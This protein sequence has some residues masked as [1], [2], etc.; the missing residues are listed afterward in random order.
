MNEFDEVRF[1]L[2]ELDTVLSLII[3]ILPVPPFCGLLFFLFTFFGLLGAL[4]PYIVWPIIYFWLM[5]F[6]FIDNYEGIIVGL[7]TT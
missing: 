5:L 3:V 6:K 7:P 4:T 1:N 2:V